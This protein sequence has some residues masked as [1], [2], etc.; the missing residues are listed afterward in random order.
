[1]VKDSCHS[2]NGLLEIWRVGEDSNL[3][4]VHE[5]SDRTSEEEIIEV[6]M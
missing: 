4:S 3:S 6:E 5:E 1:M 2:G